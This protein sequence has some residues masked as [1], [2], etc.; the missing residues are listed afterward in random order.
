MIEITVGGYFMLVNFVDAIVILDRVINMNRYC[1]TRYSEVEIGIFV[2]AM[3]VRK[4]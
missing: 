3:L 4:K 1:H 2:V